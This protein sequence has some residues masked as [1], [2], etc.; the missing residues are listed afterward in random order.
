[1]NLK[2]P[3]TLMNRHTNNT[4]NRHTKH[5]NGLITGAPGIVV[6]FII[7]VMSLGLP[8][9]AL[10]QT[11][12]PVSASLIFENCV[13]GAID[14]GEGVTLHFIM[15]NNTASTFS[16]VVVSLQTSGNVSSPSGAQ[17]LATVSPH[18]E[19]PVDFSFIATGGCGGTVT[20]TIVLTGGV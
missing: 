7:L 8:A 2:T 5:T 15:T 3:Q 17:L 18:S 20:P 19:F 10:A 9:K 12:S 13:N 6:A 11:I 14:P 16:S 4:M 1:M